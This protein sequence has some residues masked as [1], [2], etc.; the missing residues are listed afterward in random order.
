MKR[1]GLCLEQV[2]SASNLAQA[3]WRAAKG[4]PRDRQV[5]LWRARVDQELATLGVGILSGQLELGR[6]RTF[7]I[8]DPKPRT[9]RAPCFQERVLHHALMAVVGPCL[10]RALVDDT[11]ACRVGKGAHAAARRAQVHLRRFPWRVQIDI[12]AYFASVHHVTL[13][14]LL[15]RRLKGAAGLTLIDRI[16][17]CHADGPGRGLPIGALTSQHFANY[18]L[19]SFDRFLLEQLRVCGMVRYMDDIVWWCSSEREARDGVQRARTFLADQLRLEIKATPCVAAS[20]Q[21]LNLCGFRVFP[22]ALLLSPRR[23][24]R[25]A[26]ARKQWERAYLD[27]VIDE[28]TLQAGYAAARA[29]TGQADANGFCRE[30]LRRVPECCEC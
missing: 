24:R 7:R 19:S 13:K 26:A 11:F 30:Q 10:D 20:R 27:G 17:D 12:R 29:I 3:F 9:I 5:A 28:R 6:F 2:A 21:G 1:T 14:A 8:R 4:S 23:K 16:V 25:Y 18:Y 15:R 22:G